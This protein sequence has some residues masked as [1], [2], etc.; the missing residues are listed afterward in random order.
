MYKFL[1]WLAWPS[2]ERDF[3]PTRQLARGPRCRARAPD[4]QMRPR[5]P[6]SMHPPTTP[7]RS[8]PTSKPVSPSRPLPATSTGN[9][10]AY[11]P[12]GRW[13]ARTTSART[14]PLCVGFRVSSMSTGLGSPDGRRIT[15]PRF[16]CAAPSRGALAQ[17]ACDR[18]QHERPRGKVCL[19]DLSQGRGRAVH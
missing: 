18:G 11:S 16:H 17:Q 10:A 2:R 9:L 4:D 8:L 15:T 5:A 7:C 6:C 12:P 13:R 1:M 14:S 19:L 3:A